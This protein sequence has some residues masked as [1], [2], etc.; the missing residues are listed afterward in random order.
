[1]A[2]AAMLTV[3]VSVGAAAPTRAARGTSAKAGKL[4]LLCA[5]S[6]QL[7]ICARSVCVQLLR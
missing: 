2:L 3:L 6:R 5:R 1:M 7:E 4:S